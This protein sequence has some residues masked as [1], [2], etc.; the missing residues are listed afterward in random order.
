[1]K[2]V[3]Q[4]QLGKLLI[5]ALV[6]NGWEIS[7]IEFD[8]DWWAEEYWLIHSVRENFGLKVILSFLVFGEDIGTWKGKHVE[9]LTASLTRPTYMNPRDD[10]IAVIH[11]RN[12]LD[13]TDLDI[14]FKD[15]DNFL[16]DRHQTM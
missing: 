5:K 2:T 4:R 13:G 7:D 11:V 10:D 16:E 12:G 3:E 1:M 14:F 15:L 8:T 9:Y 6:K